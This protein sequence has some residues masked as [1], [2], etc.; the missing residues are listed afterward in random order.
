MHEV[1]GAA[2]VEALY[3]SATQIPEVLQLHLVLDTL[4]S[5]SFHMQLGQFLTRIRK[6]AFQR[7]TTLLLVTQSL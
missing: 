6:G 7:L 2:E 3:E 5:L 4:E 1:G